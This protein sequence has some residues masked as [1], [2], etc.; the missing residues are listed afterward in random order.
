MPKISLL[1]SQRPVLTFLIAPGAP[2]M[3]AT[4]RWDCFWESEYSAPKKRQ[5][6]QTPSSQYILSSS[7]SK[8]KNLEM[9]LRL[10]A[11]WCFLSWHC[12]S[13]VVPIYHLYRYFSRSTYISVIMNCYIPKYKAQHAENNNIYKTG[14][15]R[16]PLRYPRV[17][18]TVP[19][20]LRTCS[21]SSP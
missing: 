1:L 6:N 20:V 9:N 17:F 3:Y 19:V 12:R 4:G 13:F 5:R 21:V 2:G 8:T 16:I 18:L 14:V 15:D 7:G 10:G 11:R